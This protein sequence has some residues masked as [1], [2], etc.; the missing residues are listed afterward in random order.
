M[1]K[2]WILSVCILTLGSCATRK[3]EKERKRIQLMDKGTIEKKSPGDVIFI[4][5]PRVPNDRKP[6]ELYSGQKGATA[7]LNFDEGGVLRDG[8]INCPEIDE[9]EQKNLELDYTSR[10]K[11]SERA[12]NEM[13]LKEIKSTVIWLTLIISLAWVA[14]GFILRK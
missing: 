11:K 9:L 4:P 7:R 13:A 10:E 5:A 12:F 14:R 1:R 6:V 3:V 2:I 8:I